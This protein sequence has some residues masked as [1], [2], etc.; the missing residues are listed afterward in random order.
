MPGIER[1]GEEPDSASR[2]RGS[3]MAMSTVTA[4]AATATVTSDRIMLAAGRQPS[5]RQTRMSQRGARTTA[6]RGRSA[7]RRPHDRPAHARKAVLGGIASD[8][9]FGAERGG[10]VGA[11]PRELR[12]TP[13]EVAER[14]G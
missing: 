5:G 14:G 3:V 7:S 10:F 4:A 2:W 9:G 11:L 1:S 6:S 12:L 8:A 13:A